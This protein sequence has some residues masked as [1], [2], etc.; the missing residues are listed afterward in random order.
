MNVS[1]GQL[2]DVTEYVEIC[3]G[4]SSA[5]A[6]AVRPYLEDPWDRAPRRSLAKTTTIAQATP[7]VRMETVTA[8]NQM[9]DRIAKILATLPPVFQM[10]NVSSKLVIPCA[11]VYRVSNCC[12]SKGL[13]S[14]L[15]SARPILAVKG[16]SA[17]IP[18][19][20]SNANVHLE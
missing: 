19:E 8:Q 1:T 15:T 12:Q 18:L 3:L 2:A 20:D 5:V 13:A 7:R 17:R 11:G 4:L 6:S 9:L 10:P 14:T 16:P